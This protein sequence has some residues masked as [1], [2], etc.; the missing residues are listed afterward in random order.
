MKVHA[1]LPGSV[2]AAICLGP[3]VMGALGA[4]SVG[5]PA[6]PWFLGLTGLFLGLAFYLAYHRVP[7]TWG[8]EGDHRAP[9]SRRVQRFSVWIVAVLTTILATSPQWSSAMRTHGGASPQ[10]SEPV[11]AP[12]TSGAVTLDVKGMTCPHCEGHVKQE[13][14]RVQGVTAARVSFATQ[15]AVVDVKKS[16]DP[17]A[18]MAAVAKAGYRASIAEPR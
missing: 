13:L 8:S 3:V 7:P 5:S 1:S 10:P 16:V 2:L 15:S 11:P 6:G 9:P 4:I 12:N 17:S 14:L 18:L